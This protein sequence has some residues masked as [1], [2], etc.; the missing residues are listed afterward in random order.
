M[1]KK[2]LI[3]GNHEIVIYNFR[4][5]LIERLLKENNEVYLSFPKGVR[6]EYFEDLGCHFI[7]TKI[8]R[9]GINPMKDIALLINY[10]RMIKTIKP[11]F[12]LTYTIKPNIY[13]GLA[14]RIMKK[15]Y[16]TNITGIG[17]TFQN[18]DILKKFIVSL[19]KISLKNAQM[20]F[21][22]N[23]ENREVFK[24]NKIFAKDEE[25]LPGSGV[26]LLEYD[27][28]PKKLGDEINFLYIGRIM[29]DKGIEEYLYAANRLKKQNLKCNFHIIGFFEEEKYREI[30]NLYE[31]KNIVNYHGFQDDVKKYIMRSDCIVNPSHHEG[32]SNVLL[33]A[34]AI[35][36][37]LIAT[38]ISGCKEI[39]EDSVNGYTFE[40]KNKESLFE[41]LVKF[42]NLTRKEK[43]NMSLA[44][45]KKM[46]LE[47]DRNII[48]NNYL[49]LIN[50]N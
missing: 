27:F 28:S 33:E 15:N 12:V 50:K 23:S 18:N 24:T 4:K 46:E 45:R 1:K 3:L 35:G 13:G 40:V 44:S 32:M 8:E 10:M 11:D 38:N 2:I 42:S 36:R 20:I 31:E 39:I 9:H 41:K 22:Q 47:F 5:E 25:V 7:E 49:K 14:A 21:F 37:A 17:K 43:E 26:N 48:I 16:I 29:K 34:G 6:G 30:I 19:Y